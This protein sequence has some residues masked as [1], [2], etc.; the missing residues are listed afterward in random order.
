M[1]RLIKNANEK[2]MLYHSTTDDAMVIES[3]PIN[4]NFDIYSY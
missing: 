1:W 3:V 4:Y 2:L